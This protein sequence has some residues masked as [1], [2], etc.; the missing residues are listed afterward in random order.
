MHHPPLRIGFIG[1]GLNSAVGYTHYTSSHL[2]GLFRLEAGC[3]SRD[4]AINHATA[5]L[6]AVHPSRTYATWRK[7]VE[8]EGGRLDAVV[9]LTPTPSHAEIVSALLEVGFL[10]IC[11]KALATSV[12]ECTAIEGSLAEHQGFL[13]VTYNYSGYPMFRE[14][15][16]RCRAW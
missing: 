6:Y 3:F 5:E 9:V 7:M 12:A 16:A 14:L 1:G 15:V 4:A 10:V 11:E 2:D 8:A 13:A